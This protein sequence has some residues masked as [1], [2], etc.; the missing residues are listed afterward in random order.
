M[1]VTNSQ[2]YPERENVSVKHQDLLSINVSTWNGK[3]P[4]GITLEV[5][6]LSIDFSGII[7]GDVWNHLVFCVGS[8]SY[9][10]FLNGKSLQEHFYDH[11]KRPKGTSNSNLDSH[12]DGPV[13]FRHVLSTQIFLGARPNF[14][15]KQ[16]EN[17]FKG[18]IKNVTIYHTEFSES[19]AKFIYLLERQGLKYSRKLPPPPP[20]Q[21]HSSFEGSIEYMGGK[22]ISTRI[23]ARFPLDSKFFNRC[24]TN[25]QAYLIP[26]GFTTHQIA[27]SWPGYEETM[28]PDLHQEDPTE[29]EEEE[30]GEEELDCNSRDLNE[31]ALQPLKESIEEQLQSTKNSQVTESNKRA[32]SEEF[33]DPNDSKRRKS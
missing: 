21:K 30:E 23:Q 31:N 2:P 17:Y 1:K 15:T 3:F 10:M 24:T 4:F 29:E 27:A 6:D 13:F 11:A 9:K 19:D 28:A 33:L 26:H 14:E 16:M 32:R 22:H 20:H 8:E 5:L 25:S 18:A 12:W 7:Y